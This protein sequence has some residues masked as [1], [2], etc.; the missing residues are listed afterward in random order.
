M[1]TR[2]LL[3]EH[4]RGSG[5]GELRVVASMAPRKNA[6]AAAPPLD[7]PAPLL[8]NVSI[9]SEKEL[10][11]AKQLLTLGQGHVFKQW[12]PAGRDD[13]PKHAF[14]Q[15]VAS[16]H[17]SYPGGLQAYVAKARRL[18]AHAVKGE[19]PLAGWSPS[20]PPT[21]CGVQLTP[22][23]AEFE[24][25][26]A[27]GL[28]A[29]VGLT[30]AVPAGGLG[31]RLG[32]SDVRL[33]L[34]SE[35]ASGKSALHVYATHVCALQQLLTTRLGRDVRLPLLIMT[36]D[37][38]HA[39]VSQMLEQHRHYGLA[40]TQV[41][42]LKQNKVAA[43]ADSDAR[44]VCE[45]DDPYRLLTKP[46]GHGDLHALLH[47][48]GLAAKWLRE[49]RR[50]L[51]LFQ[52]SSTLYFSTYLATLGVAA[53]RGLAM[54]FATTP[55]RA[56]MALGVLATLA[57]DKPEMKGNRRAETRPLL[58]IEYNQLEPLLATM[59]SSDVNLKQTGFSAYPG[60]TNGLVLG[61]GPYVAALAPVAG[62][63]REFVNPKYADAART[64]FVSPTRLECMMQDYAW[65][66]PHGARVG[67]VGYP[68]EFGYY[69]CKNVLGAAAKLAAAGV[70]PYA[71]SSSE[72]AVY[73]A[74]AS[75]LRLLGAHVAPPRERVFHGVPVALGPA[76]VL[77]PSFCPCLS[78]LRAKLPT[79]AEVHVSETSTLLVDGVDV[80]I[81]QLTLD[82]ALEVRVCAAASLV[83]RS[84]HVRNDGWQF[85]E[86]SE[87]VLRSASCP[88]VLRIRGYTLRKH[89]GR[90]VAVD[91]PGAWIVEDG[92]LRRDDDAA[93]AAAAVASGGGVS[94]GGKGGS[95]STVATPRGSARGG[96]YGGTAGPGG[97]PPVASVG[98]AIVASVPPPEASTWSSTALSL[99]PR[100]AMRVPLVLGAPS[101]VVLEVA[102][103]GG[104]LVLSLL[105]EA[106]PPL[107]PPTHVPPVAESG[108][109][110]GGGG[111]SACC[112]GSVH[113]VHVAGTGVFSVLLENRTMLSTV[114]CRAC[115]R[116][117]PEEV[118]AANERLE[119]VARYQEELER[120]ERQE[121]SLVASEA[122]LTKR[123]WEIS[124]LRRRQAA[125]IEQLRAALA[126]ATSVPSVSAAP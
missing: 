11:S 109:T 90:T 50:W 126:E 74:H 125:M 35:I 113:D 59:G 49:G 23:S 120:L 65:L 101:R 60:N 7:W 57:P 6:A 121:A 104:P 114:A 45:P 84:L 97:G 42:L 115:V 51:F 123:L 75:A 9:L 67:Y 80:T 96:A 46:H 61:L 119:A 28:E 86:L 103:R 12:Q 106:G 71:A 64:A 81:E 31:E 83:I 72:F 21:D 39:R 63:V 26:E 91:E 87:A 13:E 54:A 89:G 5:N 56:K 52:D 118:V 68:L 29:A 34:P 112:G 20:V 17:A 18:L 58:P 99:A 70:P 16:L 36:S 117:Q 41:T 44:F 77:A 100:S 43:L 40:P 27:L 82:G 124:E 38:T 62:L 93:A 14:F 95:G 88:E 107:L 4:T 78:L 66:L 73:H 3:K 8:A 76:V 105:P 47:A 32:Y 19:N 22:G 15:Q 98:G 79:P 110:G 25:Y 55:R 94:G 24:R 48:S 92:V 1:R 85:D 111:G 10:A 2:A 53:E 116:H 108:A 30:F 122:D 37:D 69:P 102:P 33:S